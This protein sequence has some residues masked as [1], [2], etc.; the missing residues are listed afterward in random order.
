[1]KV[2]ALATT[3]RRI[4]FFIDGAS[5]ATLYPFAP[6]LIGVLTNQ[7]ADNNEEL[8]PSSSTRPHSSLSPLPW[9]TMTATP[10][11]TMWPSVSFYTAVMVA[12]YLLGRA[13]G[14][15]FISKHC[16]IIQYYFSPTPSTVTA[17]NTSMCAGTTTTG[18]NS[19]AFS[20]T[21]GCIVA[22]HIFSYGLGF[23]HHIAILWLIRF[24]MGIFNGL[25]LQI[26]LSS[27]STSVRGTTSNKS[28]HCNYYKKKSAA[29]FNSANHGH[30][31]KSDDLMK[32][33][34]KIWLI[35]FALSALSSGLFYVPFHQSALYTFL[36]LDKKYSNT[37]L[38][39][40]IS[41]VFFVVIIFTT[42]LVFDCFLKFIPDNGD[43]DDDHHHHHHHHQG[44]KDEEGGGC[45]QIYKNDY[46][47]EVDNGNHLQDYVLNQNHL[48]YEM[49]A[50]N[51]ILK[52]R[53]NAIAAATGSFSG[54]VISNSNN[55]FSPHFV[56]NQSHQP[57]YNR[58]RLGSY[59]SNV[60][61]VFFDCESHFGDSF[62]Y[63]IEAGNFDVNVH[64]RASTNNDADSNDDDVDEFILPTSSTAV[65]TTTYSTSSNN[66][67]QQH[68]DQQHHQQLVR[69][70]DNSNSVTKYQNKKCVFEDG[71]PSNVPAGCTPSKVSNAFQSYYKTGAAQKWEEMKKW[72]RAKKIY[73]I[74][75]RPHSLFPRIK[76][77]YPHFIHGY[78]KFG[79]PVIYEQPANMM[80]KDMF[81]EGH[82]VDDMVYH[83][84]YFLEYLSNVLC[85][86]HPEMKKRLDARPQ[87]EKNNCDW[88][89]VVVMDVASIS[90]SVFS[91]A[92][93]QYLQ[94]AGKVNN[95]YYPNTT[96][97]ALLVNS[98][99]WLSGVFG[100]IRP[101]IPSSAKADLIG[102]SNLKERLTEYIDEDQIPKEYGGTSPYL[103]DQ[104]PFELQLHSLVEQGFERRDDDDDNDDDD[105][106]DDDEEEEEIED[107]KSHYVGEE[108]EKVVSFGENITSTNSNNW[109]HSPTRNNEPNDLE[110]SNG[111]QPIS[112][113]YTPDIHHLSQHSVTFVNDTFET[114]NS[115]QLNSAQ[116]SEI[117]CTFFNISIIYWLSCAVQGAIEV[118]LPLWFLVPKELGGLGYY[119][120]WSGISLFT[121]TVLIIWIMNLNRR[122]RRVS[123]IPIRLPVKGYR[124]GIGSKAV[125]LNFLP[126]VPCISRH[127]NIFVFIFIIL[128]GASIFVAAMVGRSSSAT[129]HS[130]ASS[131]YHDKLSL[132][133]DSRTTRLGRIINILANL[134][135]DGGLTWMLG[136]SGEL[137]GAL[138]VSPFMKWSL[139]GVHNYPFNAALSFHIGGILCSAL[140]IFSF[141]L[142]INDESLQIRDPKGT[143]CSLFA[144][145]INVAASDIAALLEATNV[146]SSAFRTSKKK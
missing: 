75:S 134:V 48:E 40:L 142:K 23:K 19:K 78:S 112:S 9:A 72:R 92:V 28:N 89:F 13:I 123:Q 135:R 77:A 62:D 79:Y 146:S 136:T 26:S 114:P 130:I 45:D 137:F 88:G 73:K 14:L 51:T 5:R 107:E 31:N 127:E 71:S 100:K 10:P 104:H 8:I 91:G 58:A 70:R 17:T 133:C 99:F 117:E 109:T 82:T 34:N 37:S 102:A 46:G 96:T 36:V 83:Y 103:L 42:Q 81:E 113:F 63:D 111:S 94:K 129:L 44:E 101:F 131:S 50:S 86:E 53:K 69:W 118:A 140:Y 61:D 85:H 128:F 16:K 21:V 57:T 108:I 66:E 97:L 80:L 115:V 39:S 15:T 132:S 144:N 119:P 145:I 29:R 126:F 139:Q 11:L 2:V 64:T 122:L 98:P 6:L 76:E 124:I 22:L 116:Y 41:F 93:L 141:S 74:H 52:R 55:A 35:G 59:Q 12:A 125:L 49:T 120:H 60:S 121:S 95:N 105:D 84:T 87:E 24:L 33:T 56:M 43:G 18:N 4:A 110:E 138:L 38:S 25:I 90:L 32:P 68:K 47:N 3:K 54:D 7:Y 30:S 143:K 20:T 67:E 27:T 65:T 106:D 1:M